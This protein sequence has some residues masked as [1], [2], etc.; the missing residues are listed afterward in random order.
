[1]E[2][3]P[4][5]LLEIRGHELAEAHESGAAV[6]RR[7]QI[8]HLRDEVLVVADQHDV[9]RAGLQRFGGAL[10]RDVHDLALAAQRDRLVAQ[11]DERLHEA[12]RQAVARRRGRTS[13]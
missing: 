5:D 4:G 9:R 8:R 12:R 13:P 1:M 11:R 3:D 6:R 2:L 10:D 7:R